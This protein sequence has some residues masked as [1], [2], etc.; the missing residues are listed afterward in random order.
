MNRA[1]IGLCPLPKAMNVTKLDIMF[2][3]QHFKNLYPQFDLNI[4]KSIINDIC[5]Y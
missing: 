4:F 1:T 2:D 5:K 3:P